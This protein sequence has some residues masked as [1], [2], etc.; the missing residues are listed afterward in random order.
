MNAGYHAILVALT[1]GTLVLS[2]LAMSYRFWIRP[3]KPGGGAVWSSTDVVAVYSAVFGTVM[4]L[5]AAGSGLMLRPLEALLNSPITKNKI[6]C[7]VLA[8]VCWSSF[9]VLRLKVGPRLWELRGLV[10]H[11]AYVMALAGLVFVVTASSIGG[12]L[13]GIPSGYEQIGQAVG[14]RTRFTLY[15]PTAM[16]VLLWVI[17][18]AA[19]GSVLLRVRLRRVKK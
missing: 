15:F 7:T 1:T 9:L 19:L 3:R 5:L 13:A 12:D 2:F 17:G 10:R 16:N 8:L 11:Y 18:V 6:L 4:L 14:F